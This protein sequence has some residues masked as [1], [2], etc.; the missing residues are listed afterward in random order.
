MMSYI[1]A[2]KT[3]EINNNNRSTIRVIKGVDFLLIFFLYYVR[4]AFLNLH[5]IIEDI[6]EVKLYT[7]NN[8]VRKRK[9]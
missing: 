6:H 9:K 4:Y 7:R 8:K 2:S 1:I 5:N 3:C